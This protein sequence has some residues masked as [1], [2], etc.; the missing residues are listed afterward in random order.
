MKKFLENRSNV[1]ILNV[2]RSEL[3]KNEIWNIGWLEQRLMEQ[4]PCKGTRQNTGE[5]RAIVGGG[6]GIFHGRTKGIMFVEF[7]D[8]HR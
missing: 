7:K 3:I 2:D 5:G 4:D 8:V 1:N 6:S